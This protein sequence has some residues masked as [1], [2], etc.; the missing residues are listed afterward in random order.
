MSTAAYSH[1]AQL[2]AVLLYRL[3]QVKILSYISNITNMSYYS[4]FQELCGLCPTFLS[5]ILLALSV[6]PFLN[7]NGDPAC[8]QVVSVDVWL[9]LFHFS[10]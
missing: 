4:L 10:S 1:A 3:H 7:L 8:A 2:A 9:L 6:E 5:L